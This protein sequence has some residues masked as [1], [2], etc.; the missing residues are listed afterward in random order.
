MSD[1]PSLRHAWLSHIGKQKSENQ[2]V[3][4][5]FPERRL[6]LL[7]D[8]MGG[9]N[10]GGIASKMTAQGLP[11]RLDP[12]EGDPVAQLDRQ[13]R[14]L[15]LEIFQAGM[16]SRACFYMGAT[17]T[18]LWWPAQQP[19]L[20]HVA[21]S[22]AYRLRGSALTQLT[23]DHKVVGG[24]QTARA[25]GERELEP[26]IQLLDLA[27]GDRVLIC[28]DGLTKECDNATIATLLGRDQSPEASCA[29]LQQAALEAGGRDNISVL[30][31]DVG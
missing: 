17:L 27:Q 13:L 2:D 23:Q 31:I 29:T 15:S 7:S 22:R 18:L 24:P 14:E 21:D 9:T 10:G 1:R 6:F 30:V 20:C 26:E 28:S 11:P 8:G 5:V 25:V 12:V 4:A 16:R 19:I 3:V